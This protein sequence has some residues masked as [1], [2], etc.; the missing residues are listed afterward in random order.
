MDITLKGVV[1]MIEE[2]EL[3]VREFFSGIINGD[4]LS[5]DEEIFSSGL[6]NSLFAMQLILYIEKNYPIVVSNDDLDI[7]NFNTIDGIVQFI[8]ARTDSKKQ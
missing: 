4:E 8:E 5:G 6:V 3:H 7:D 2:I 1:I